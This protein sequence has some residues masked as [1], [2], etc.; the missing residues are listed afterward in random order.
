MPILQ[1]NPKKKKKNNPLLASCDK[2]FGDPTLVF[3]PLSFSLSIM[4]SRCAVKPASTNK[5]SCNRKPTKKK[6][7]RTH[8]QRQ[9]PAQV[10]V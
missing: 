2:S 3:S 1:E 9:T 4:L 10:S 7:T 6:T 5:H 8:K